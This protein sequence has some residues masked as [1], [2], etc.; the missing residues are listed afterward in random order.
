VQEER[1]RFSRADKDDSGLATIR[2]AARKY[3][4]DERM[5]PVSRFS[6]RVTAALM[7]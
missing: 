7:V 1:K 6:L 2:D 4:R 3:D 5:D